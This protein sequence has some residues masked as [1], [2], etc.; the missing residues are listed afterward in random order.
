MEI[1]NLN[2]VLKKETASPHRHGINP[3]NLV[4]GDGGFQATLAGTSPQPPLPL[5]KE[6]KGL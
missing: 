3:V 5:K 1:K 4:S 6:K 2:K